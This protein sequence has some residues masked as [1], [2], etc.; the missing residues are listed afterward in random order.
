MKTKSL[1]T[2]PGYALTGYYLLGYVF[3]LLGTLISA[4]PVQ[5]QGFDWARRGGNKTT[6][7]VDSDGAGNSYLLTAFSGSV[8]FGSYSFSSLGSSSRSD[9]C[10]VK[11]DK[12]GTVKWAR[13]IGGNGNDDLGDVT[14]SKYGGYLYI[15]GTFEQTVRFGTYHGIMSSPLT[16]R[17]GKDIFVARYEVNSG[18]F[19]WAKQAGGPYSD[20]ANGIFT[21]KYGDE[22]FITGSFAGTANFSTSG[23]AYN[24]S[25]Y[26]NS[27]DAYYAK[28]DQNGNFQQAKRWGWSGYDYGSAIAVN[29]WDDDIYVTG[30]DSPDDS[31]Y[32]VNFYLRKM[33]RLGNYVW[34]KTAGESAYL[35]SGSDLVLSDAA[36]TIYVTGTYGGTLNLGGG[37]V[38]SSNG[39]SDAFAAKYNQ[40]GSVLWAKSFGGSG[41]DEGQSIDEYFGEIYLSG[42]FSTTVAFGHNSHTAVGSR[43]I[44]VARVLGNN[45]DFVWSQPL[46]S[47]SLDYGRGNISINHYQRMYLSGYRGTTMSFGAT[48]LSGS[49]TF[50]TQ[51][52]PPS[53]PRITDFWLVNADTDEEIKKIYGF[54]TIKYSDVGTRN[55]AIKMYTNPG[56]VGSVLSKYDFGAP[57]T[58]NAAP[59]AYPGNGFSGGN[60]NY[61]AFSP[62]AGGHRLE[63][64][65]YSSANGTGVKGQTSLLFFTIVDDLAAR[66]ATSSPKK[67]DA[68]A[69]VFSTNTLTLEV[70]P[71]PVVETATVAFRAT[72]D[73]PTEL[74]IYNVQGALV[75]KLFA[76]EVQAG[77]R[78]RFNIDGQALKSSLYFARL[79]TNRESIVQRLIVE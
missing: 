72:E 36:A 51:I 70:Y 57:A 65:P 43:D 39:Y 58:E 5:A 23:A 69:K 44:Y 29:S 22:V 9:L 55:I 68:T 32:I 6:S 8:S 15:T 75:Q 41:T 77:K 25:G 45:G 10:L 17:G 42:T 46:G 71:N 61:Q 56:T 27:T 34:Q 63:S 60:P 13:R 35:E 49:G 18:I 16:S 40:L 47:S 53:L 33:N 79:K 66:T 78:Y 74:V 28:Y 38:L 3:F 52:A 64:T 50:L 73:G 62:A 7:A 37:H 2:H 54:E 59:Y 1:R 19:Q 24:L 14:I 31:P 20:Y 4:Y 12:D 76:G 48:T 11:Y 21:D 30:G 26:Q 67:G